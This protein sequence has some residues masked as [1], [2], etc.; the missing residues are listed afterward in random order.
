[1]GFFKNKDNLDKEVE[2]S[3]GEATDEANSNTVLDFDILMDE[4]KMLWGKVIQ[5]DKAE[6]ASKILEE[7]FGKPTRFS[8]ITS[9]QV[10][11]LNI[12]IMKIK[13]IL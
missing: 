11:K 3:G 4:A 12:V 5:F 10:E 13:D 6:A 8:E 7:E 9:D 1:M 2:V